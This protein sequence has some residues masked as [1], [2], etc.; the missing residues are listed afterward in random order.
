MFRTQDFFPNGQCL[1]LERLGFDIPAQLVV[2]A[3]Q[4]AERFGRLRVFSSQ[5]FLQQFNGLFV[6][7]FRFSITP[8]R[9]DLDEPD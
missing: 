1:L 6:P 2:E 9:S 5:G 8:L 3:A 7:F 4:A